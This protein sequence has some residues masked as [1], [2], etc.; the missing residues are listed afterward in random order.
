MESLVRGVTLA[1]SLA[2][3]ERCFAAAARALPSAVSSAP[4]CFL[5]AAILSRY[6]FSD[7][8]SSPDSGPRLAAS[9]AHGVATF[10]RFAAYLLPA[11]PLG[12]RRSPVGES[13]TGP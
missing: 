13:P 7:T 9:T 6:S 2:A 8:A 10:L 1:R 3:S 11:E 5:M 12:G 4:C